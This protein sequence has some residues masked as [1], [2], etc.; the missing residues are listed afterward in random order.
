MNVIILFGPEIADRAYNLY[1]RNVFLIISSVRM[2]W[3]YACSRK[4]NL[5][6]HVC[7]V[8]RARVAGK[9]YYFSAVSHCTVKF[10][11]RVSG[12]LFWSVCVHVLKAAWLWTAISC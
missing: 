9:Q 6:V 3:K 11:H 10:S 2:K 12:R 8:D 4:H 5:R 1:G 7:Y